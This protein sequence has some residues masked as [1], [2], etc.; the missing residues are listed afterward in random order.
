[1]NDGQ[2]L[3]VLQQTPVICAVKSPSELEDALKYDSSII[4]ILF[5][6]VLSISDITEK[7]NKAGKQ[8]FIHVD[9]IEGLSSK[10]VAIDY[11][12]KNTKVDGIIST[13]SNVLRRAKKLEL[14][15]IH[16]FF[17]L[18][19]LAIENIKN[20]IPFKYADAVEILPGAMPKVIKMVSAFTQ[21]P[22]IASGLINDKEDVVG[23]L[24]AGAISVSSTNPKVW[25]L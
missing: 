17:V 1:M 6:N 25:S 20:H 13:K 23:V 16:R 7:V 24:K 2:L 22:V 14:F 5:G 18:D 8:A 15:T 19:S 10:E 9:L 21:K 11:L 4:F 3:E 12:V